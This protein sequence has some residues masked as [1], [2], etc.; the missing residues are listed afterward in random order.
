MRCQR[1]RWA[2]RKLRAH[3]RAPCSR[4]RCAGRVSLRSTASVAGGCA[5]THS[6]SSSERRRRCTASSRRFRRHPHAAVCSMIATALGATA[7]S[8]TCAGGASAL[9]RG[10][11][12]CGDTGACA[13]ARGLRAAALKLPARIRAQ[14]ALRRCRTRAR[15]RLRPVGR[16]QQFTPHA[17]SPP[18]T[19]GSASYH[20]P[21]PHRAFRWALGAA[22]C[23]EP[24]AYVGPSCSERA[25]PER[26]SPLRGGGP[27]T[28]ELTVRGSVSSHEPCVRASWCETCTSRQGHR[29]APPTPREHTQW[30]GRTHCR[31]VLASARR[32][33]HRA[34]GG[35]LPR[36]ARRQP[37][38]RAA[39]KRWQGVKQLRMVQ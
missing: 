22:E 9:A 23:A 30:W 3:L 16:E 21:L 36:Q 11:G 12:G 38:R 32:T 18:L 20:R 4:C 5:A 34:T 2:G 33:T 14:R 15:S 25:E 19:G 8:V 13:L 39:A 7:V 27:K 37:A 24:D 28:C 29:C 26:Q 10:R 35:A 17:F 6:S 1:M 31:L